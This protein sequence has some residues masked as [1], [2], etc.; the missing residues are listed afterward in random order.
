LGKLD[1]K[2][3]DCYMVSLCQD[4]PSWSEKLDDSK[5]LHKVV[6]I[7]EKMSKKWGVGTVVIPALIEVDEMMRRIPDGKVTTINEI[8]SVIAKKHK[9]TIGCPMTPGIFA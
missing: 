3:E 6:K 1:K 7:T 9:A 8:R 2:H 5:G 4:R